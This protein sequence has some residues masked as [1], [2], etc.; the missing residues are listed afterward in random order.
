M[1]KLFTLLLT[2]ATIMSLLPA[3]LTERA[4]GKA[5]VR[6][7]FKIKGIVARDKTLG[8]DSL[9]LGRHV[10]TCCADDIAF[11]GLVCKFDKDVDFKTRDWLTV[12]ATLV[13]EEHKLY[14]RVGPVLH[15]SAWERTEAPDPEV[16]TF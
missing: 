15:V 12:T 10:M 8:K 4:S 1:K 14:R 2:L 3:T 6:Q 9:V 11:H 13:P 16:A 7:I 5:E